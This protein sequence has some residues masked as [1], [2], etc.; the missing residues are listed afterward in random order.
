M[1]YASEPLFQAV[2]VAA[3]GGTKAS[4]PGI[5]LPGEKWGLFSTVVEKVSSLS[6]ASVTNYYRPSSL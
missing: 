4:K 2:P 6:I 3:G 5:V 1:S